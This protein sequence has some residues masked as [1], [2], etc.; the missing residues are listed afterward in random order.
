MSDTRDEP[1]TARSRPLRLLA[2]G[3]ALLAIALAVV[4]GVR[5]PIA[6][7]VIDRTFAARHVPVRYT[8]TDLGLG[9]Q[10]LTGIVIG[11]PAHPD[12]V[13]DWIE[14]ET[15]ISLSGPE[16][17]GL[18]IGHARLR[19]RLVNGRLSF[20]SLDRL[21]PAS[22]GKPSAL[23]AIDARIADL[24]VRLETVSGLVGLRISGAGRL[25]NGFRGS[26][27][28][29]SD[30]LRAGGCSG[31][32]ASAVMAI[33][34]AKAGP[35]LT[36]P[37][38]L[39]SIACKGVSART[40]AADVS[41]TLTP[42][43]DRWQGQARAHVAQIRSVGLA[44]RD[45]AGEIGF[46]GDARRTTGTIAAHSGGFTS[47]GVAGA[48][49]TLAGRYA[50]AGGAVRYDGQ[51]GGHGIAMAPDRLAPIAR[52]AG[53]AAGTPV[54]PLLNRLTAAAVA[55]GKRFDLDATLAATTAGGTPHVGVSQVALNAASGARVALAGSGIGYDGIQFTLG[56][57]HARIGGGSLPDGVATIA[58]GAS[59]IVANVVIQPYTAGAARLAL[60]PVRIGMAGGAVRIVTRATLSGPLG[61]GRVEGL[62]VPLDLRWNG[63][64]LVNPACTPVA[65][66][67]LALSGL[68]LAPSRITL[69]PTGPALLRAT[70]AGVSVAVRTGPVALDGTLGRTPL[71]LTA[72]GGG[73]DR[74]GFT[75]TTVAASIGAADR[76]TRIDV[77]RLAGRFAG[78]M[79]GGTFAGAGGRIGTVPLVLSDAA[80]DWRLAEGRLTL[81]GRLAVSD[82]Q[83]PARFKPLRAES[84]AFTLAGGAITANASLHEP[85]SGVR[86]ADV[87]IVHALGSG[88]GHA[89]LRVAALA[90][91]PG[92]QPDR[93]TPLT[94][95]VIAD[96]RGTID[97]AA[98]IAWDPRG[99]TSGGDFHTGAIDL[100]AAVGP[101]TGI[102]GTIHFTDLLALQS[103]PGQMAT[104]KTINPGI[105][106]SDGII[107]YQTLPGARVQVEGAAWPFAGGTLRLDP[108]L[109]DFAQA[110]ERRMTFHVAHVAADQFLQQ[111]DFKNL[112]A[113]GVFDGVLPMIFDAS[114]GRIEGGALKVRDGGGTLA[115]VG[116]ISQKDLG[117]WG[118]IAFQALKSLRYRSLEIALNG[119]LAGEMVTEVRFAGISQ[120]QGAKSNFLIRRLQRLPFVFNI[121]IK[122]PFRGLLDSA[123]SFYD[124]K[125]LVQRNLPQLL[126]EQDKRAAPPAP[127]PIVQPPASRIVP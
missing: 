117:T 62:A 99:V 78:G 127:A 107:R 89:D 63:G 5:K 36:G 84:V 100:A 122:A 2:G 104:V 70:A 10:R 102:A 77:G 32:G 3:T 69:C 126:E 14:T 53:R 114:G 75:L 64:L 1:P 37:V 17:A 57:A 21:L 106:V 8:L 60:A 97:G 61:D 66:A 92:F 91:T 96:V 13:A 87:T 81:G 101:V 65:F 90:F 56:R 115:Y 80:G 67:R 35:T 28:A 113:S 116:E 45:V 95:G 121:R 58:S 27:A 120:G 29:A 118:N 88:A 50:V 20:G 9:R 23:P 49:L 111:F 112:D 24:R 72:A 26:I 51:A 125:R 25:D 7:H 30:E 83:T 6:E 109:L 108:T 44:T 79:A 110:G 18:R 123:Q 86:V 19:G 39:A 52:I 31:A 42:G 16:L 46:A 68:V 59:G 103:A 34:V 22:S 105:P 43:F 85:A 55:A 124:P 74:S 38:R 94:L 33:H 82:T 48:A 40:A 12:L 119:P 73:I 93:L 71:T 76:A 15:G 11:D 54:G 41:V 47:R 98:Q 4:W